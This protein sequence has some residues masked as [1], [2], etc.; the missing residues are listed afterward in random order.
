MN[1]MLGLYL[2]L[3][4][5][6]CS[7]A[8]TFNYGTDFYLYKKNNADLVKWSEGGC[9]I[10]KWNGES[11]VRPTLY[12]IDC[13]EK[14]GEYQLEGRVKHPLFIYRIIRQGSVRVNMNQIGLYDKA[15]L[16]PGGRINMT[17][18][19]SIITLVCDVRDDEMISGVNATPPA[20]NFNNSMTF[21]DGNQI[22]LARDTHIMKLNDDDT[23]GNA[24]ANATDAFTS[25][26][27]IV[28]DVTDRTCVPCHRHVAGELYIP[29]DFVSNRIL[30]RIAHQTFTIGAGEAFFTYSHNNYEEFFEVNDASMAFALH[31]LDATKANTHPE[32]K[33][34]DTCLADTKQVVEYTKNVY[35]L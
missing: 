5:Y 26:Y 32:F 2:F 6:K 10:F 4:V 16:Y 11:Y 20:S 34:G 28:R 1:I 27:S 8:L 35:S 17:I 25:D 31:I 22:T 7:L 18:T 29:L 15:I 33:A 19:R 30:F 12:Q 24:T 23:C 9:G 21:I 14:T 3:C 13:A